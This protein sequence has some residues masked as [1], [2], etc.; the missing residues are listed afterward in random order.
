MGWLMSCTVNRYCAFYCK[1]MA[2][3]LNKNISATCEVPFIQKRLVLSNIVH[4]FVYIPVSEN[5]SFAK[6]I[7][8]PDSTGVEYQ[9][10]G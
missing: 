5:F 9:E 8:P 2:T 4:K 6:I 3:A 7:H 10:A 1:L